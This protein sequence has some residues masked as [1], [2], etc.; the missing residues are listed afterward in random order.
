MEPSLN[1]SV[2]I[3][4][5]NR[6]LTTSILREDTPQPFRIESIRLKLV[7]WNPCKAYLPLVWFLPDFY[8]GSISKGTSK[9]ELQV[10]RVCVRRR[11]FMVFADVFP[12]ADQVF[13]VDV[14]REFLATFS[15]KSAGERL[16]RML[17]TSRQNVKET[18]AILVGDGEDRLIGNNDGFS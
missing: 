12:D 13:Y 17:T 5:I 4:E 10:M 14:N 11:K 16:A 6:M 3:S 18:I 9:H 1:G 15:R 7:Q 2:H 8:N